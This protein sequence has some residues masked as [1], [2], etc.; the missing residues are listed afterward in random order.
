LAGK[1]NLAGMDIRNY[2]L[3]AINEALDDLEQGKVG[4]ALIDAQEV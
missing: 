3:D 2:R 4:R 1:L